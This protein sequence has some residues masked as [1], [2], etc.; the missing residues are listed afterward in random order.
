M[1]KCVTFWNVIMRYGL[2]WESLRFDI[3]FRSDID[4][5]DGIVS[6]CTLQLNFSISL[7]K[8]NSVV[9]QKILKVILQ[10]GHKISVLWKLKF[11]IS[12]KS[13]A[14]LALV[15]SMLMTTVYC[16]VNSVYTGVAVFMFR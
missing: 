4:V 16:G 10:W 3:Q 2:F 9:L 1:I 14:T 15:F 12:T 6:L 8:M 13:V 11:D 7:P 5:T